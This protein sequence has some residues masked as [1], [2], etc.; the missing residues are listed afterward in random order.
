[1]RSD[2]HGIATLNLFP[3][4]NAALVAFHR[5][6]ADPLGNVARAISTM[7]ALDMQ[8]QRPT[9]L[10]ASD[11]GRDHAAMLGQCTNGDNRTNWAKA[12]N[13]DTD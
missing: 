3:E 13:T 6:L 7:L 12:A 11:V 4:I 8:C 2:Q 9:F 5:K 10:F 1:M